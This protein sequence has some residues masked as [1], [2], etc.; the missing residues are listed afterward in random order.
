MYSG[1]ADAVTLADDELCPFLTKDP[2]DKN[3][4]IVAISRPLARSN[5]CTHCLLPFSFVPVW[6]LDGP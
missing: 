4:G 1:S 3:L 6:R 5:E 2:S